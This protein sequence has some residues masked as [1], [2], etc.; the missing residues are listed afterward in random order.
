[1]ALGRFRDPGSTARA[2]EAEVMGFGVE[3]SLSLF[4]ARAG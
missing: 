2:G 4:A 1:M 3:G